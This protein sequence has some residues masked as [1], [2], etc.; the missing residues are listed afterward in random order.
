MNSDAPPLQLLVVRSTAV[1]A[2]ALEAQL[3][4]RG[5]LGSAIEKRRGA[6]LVRLQAYFPSEMDV[7]VDWV[8]EKL[9][10]LH[11]YGVPVGPAEVRLLP[12]HR[13]DWAETWK[14]HWKAFRPTSRLMIVPSW[15]ADSSPAPDGMDRIL[16]DPGMAFGLGDHPTTRGC[17]QMLERIADER[18]GISG[19]MVAPPSGQ[20]GPV[21]GRTAAPPPIAP[22]IATPSAAD[23]GSGTGILSVRAVQLGLGPVDAFDT[24]ADAVRTGVACAQANGVAAA[25]AFQEGTLPATGA[26]PYRLILANI[27]LSVLEDLLPRMIRALEPQGEIVLAGI[28]SDQED[29]LRVGL[30]RRGLR[31]TDRICER[32][33]RGARRWP[34]LRAR[35]E[36]SLP[37]R[38]TPGESGL[39]DG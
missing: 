9:D 38:S 19:E 39:Q 4:E 25:I 23:I 29:R 12:L 26:G 11:S 37:G 28:L 22:T 1:A 3:A 10:E 27:F 30:E 16:M 17:L 32:T 13:E 8:R 2:E 35:F 33:Q 5:A 20:R 6:R 18:G 14:T 34:V 24:E 31:V 7:P 15:E 36:S 21:A